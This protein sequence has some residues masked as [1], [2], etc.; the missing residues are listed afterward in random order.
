MK[1][2][3]ISIETY[4]AGAGTDVASMMDNK[5]LKWTAMQVATPIYDYNLRK[6]SLMDEFFLAFAT[7]ILWNS[8]FWVS[9]LQ[10]LWR[11]F[12]W[13]IN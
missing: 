1:E 5:Q 9:M 10:Y 3:A 4:S 13:C 7:L 11:P 6:C 2:V 12:H 8:H